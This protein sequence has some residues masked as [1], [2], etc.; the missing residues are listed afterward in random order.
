MLLP[1]PNSAR[2]ARTSS[3]WGR[4]RPRPRSEPSHQFRTREMS[5]A[6]DADQFILGKALPGAAASPWEAGGFDRGRVEAFALPG[7][8]LFAQPAEI[9]ELFLQRLV[10]VL[11]HHDSGD[12][13]KIWAQGVNVAMP[14]DQNIDVECQQTLERIDPFTAVDI[15]V[16]SGKVAAHECIAGNQDLFT[17]VIKHNVVVAMTGRVEDFQFSVNGLNDA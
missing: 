9:Q 17:A 13:G 4:G 3:S 8:N 2:S 5:Q 1:F 15:R 10:R 6:E 16:R 14:F 12:F 11:A 7:F